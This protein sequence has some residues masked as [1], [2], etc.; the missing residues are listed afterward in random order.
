MTNRTRDGSV[1]SGV[2]PR[3]YRMDFHSKGEALMDKANTYPLLQLAIVEM[4]QNGLDAGARHIFVGVDRM[5]HR[6][7][8]CDDGAGITTDKFHKALTSIGHS[9]KK[10]GSL[11][12]FGL[13][14]ISPVTK[15][16]IMR[17]CSTPRGTRE[18][19]SWIFIADSIRRQSEEV[20]IPF[21]SIEALPE[22][23]EPFT[24]S[25]SIS[26]VGKSRP[27]WR[28]MVLLDRVT[29]DRAIGSGFTAE[30]LS[31]LIR[32]KL[33]LAMHRRQATVTIRLRES[34][35]QVTKERVD[36]KDY[37]GTPFREVGYDDSGSKGCGEITFRLYRARLSGGKPAGRVD[38]V[39]AGDDYPVTATE[40][41]RQADG[42]KW[43]QI[44]EVKAALE[45]LTSGFFEGIIS[46]ERIS[47]H[48]ERTKFVVDDALK[49]MAIMLGQ[50]FDDVGRG[51]MNEV[52]ED[53]QNQRYIRLG[54]KSVERLTELLRKGEGRLGLAAEDLKEVLPSR[55]MTR[56][57]K[58]TPSESGSK[59]P[60]TRGV[61]K[62]RILVKPKEDADK[63]DGSPVTPFIGFAYDLL[64]GSEHLWHF[65]LLE[66]VLTFN[67]RHP[68]WRETDEDSQGRHNAQTD[69]QIMA[70]QEWVAFK[71]IHLLVSGA[72]LGE[73]LEVYRAQIDDELEF[74]HP[75]F[76]A[77]M[78]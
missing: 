1:V 11:G 75:I 5:E 63:S 60:N 58:K 53:Q 18:G 4:I 14:M 17:I 21:E 52:R 28:T 74:Y 20:E 9:I 46:V 30:Q 13:G 26:R 45:A 37:T 68:L 76:I 65:D 39:E 55:R 49:S 64:E 61:A 24:N 78:K 6:V 40:F 36:P 67:V 73:E 19:N 77:P 34:N 10:P 48:P 59:R 57:D 27:R 3:T 31:Q 15:C 72:N 33:G 2:R 25:A 7:A 42:A 66:G 69:R 32:T 8:V 51:H 16:K 29:T 23:P 62:K 54:T 47:L 71:I 44:P 56:P 50:W 70:L 22:L 43:T 35:G 38:F 12:R 41:R